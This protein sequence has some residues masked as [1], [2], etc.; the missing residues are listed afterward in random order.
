MGSR[1]DDP[2]RIFHC[3][4]LIVD[5]FSAVSFFVLRLLLELSNR[6]VLLQFLPHS[7]LPSLH[8]A[9]V[10]FDAEYGFWAA[11]RSWHVVTIVRH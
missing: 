4:G 5:T 9:L 1:D 8:D 3:L 6:R 2:W 7:L 10:V 11:P